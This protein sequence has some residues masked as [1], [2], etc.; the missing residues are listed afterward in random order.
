[1]RIRSVLLILPLITSLCLAA[2]PQKPT[3]TKYLLSTV[4]GFTMTETDGAVYSMAYEV[5]EPLPAQV[6]VVVLFENPEA[7]KSPLRR[8][9]EV[10]ADA[11]VIQV[12]SPGIRVIR[13]DAL[14]K[15]SLSIYLD[16]GHKNLLARHDQKVLFKMG[17]EMHGFL[18]QRY[19]LTVR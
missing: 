5:R 15:V 10:P 18:Q 14:Y 17:K 2:S 8:E 9:L 16:P 1:M 12:Q 7:P 4:A 13:N 19:G 6:F 3:K 11:N